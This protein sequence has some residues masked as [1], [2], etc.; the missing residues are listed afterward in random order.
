MPSCGANRGMIGERKGAV[1]ITS[2]LCGVGS[3]GA[4]HPTGLAVL[5]LNDSSTTLNFQDAGWLLSD[6]LTSIVGDG[7]EQLDTDEG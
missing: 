6:V 1:C 2:R 3:P 7:R 4:H 5:V